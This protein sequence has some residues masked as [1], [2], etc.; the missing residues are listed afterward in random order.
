M[1]CCSQSKCGCYDP[2]IRIIGCTNTDVVGNIPMLGACSVPN[3]R[4][5]YKKKALTDKYKISEAY[6]PDI[7]PMHNGRSVAK[8][9][10]LHYQ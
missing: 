4:G 2:N 8:E 3:T 5:F 10:G 6:I 7:S 9:F 1:N